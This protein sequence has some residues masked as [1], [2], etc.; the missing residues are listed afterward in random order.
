MVVWYTV[1]YTTLYRQS[2]YPSGLCNTARR[3]AKLVALEEAFTM[4]VAREAETWQPS[5]KRLFDFL[6]MIRLGSHQ[7]ECFLVR[8]A[9]TEPLNYAIVPPWPYGL[10]SFLELF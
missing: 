10:V 2:P 9:T 8:F 7:K 5:R 6:A 1:P 3:H 4:A